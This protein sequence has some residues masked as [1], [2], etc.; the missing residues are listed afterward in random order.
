MA[1]YDIDKGSVHEAFL[2][3]RARIQIFGGGFGNGKT[4][5]M[6]IKAIQLAK[7]YPGSNGL[8]SRA[9]YAK[10][11]DTIR[12]EFFKWCPPSYIEKMPSTT[13]NTCYWKNGSVINFRY[14]GQRGK[15][16]FDAQT[17][18][19][20]LSATYDWAIVD[21]LEDPEI[22]YKDLLDLIG[23]MRGSTPYKGDDPTMPMF[24]PGFLMASLNPTANWAYQKVIKPIHEFQA[25]GH[26]SE[27]LMYDKKKYEE[28]FE[29]RP[30]VE[31]FEAPTHANKKHLPEGFIETM[32]ATYKGQMYDRFILGKWGSYEGLVYPAF[33]REV[34]L[35]PA[36][37][38][39]SILQHRYT[40]RNKYEALEGFD[41][42]I[43]VPSCYL[44]GFSDDLGR[45]IILDGFY[46]PGLTE[47]GIFDG[48]QEVR[49]R[50][51][52]YLRFREPIWAD[53][54]IFKRTQVR[55]EEVTTLGS[56]LTERG[57][58]IKPGQNAIES[59][60]MKVTSY[61]ALAPNNGL[62]DLSVPGPNLLFSDDLQFVA[63]EFA[64]YF[65]QTNT[66]GD[67]IDKPV[68]RND[69]A[70]DT[71]KL[72]LSRLP[73]ATELIYLQ[74]PVTPEMLKWHERT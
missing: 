3:S 69:H 1:R 21:Q 73:D 29:V 20:L 17:T 53:P 68:D 14:L 19:N 11:N 56:L 71:I 50:W 67:R 24:G 60:I 10:L 18:S 49:D 46:K 58:Y 32:E 12:R 36:Q 52:A 33:D 74:P 40:E 26:V 54:A 59:G 8:I 30:I 15:K 64:T 28:T 23:R 42:G 65:W 39:K 9:T 48:I 55:G 2:N 62:F 5:A 13:D 31:L 63:D 51:S 47:K 37:Q 72:M 27:D 66:M 4:A 22:V 70:M 34:H 16:S 61:L 45:V 41:F 44:L 6:C 35:V 43:G 57:L 7:G 38:I 25:T